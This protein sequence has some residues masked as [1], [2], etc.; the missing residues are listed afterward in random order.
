MFL[1]GGSAFLPANLGT[2][3]EAFGQCKKR[4]L[5]NFESASSAYS[6]GAGSF[7][8]REVD[9]QFS[10]RTPIAHQKVSLPFSYILLLQIP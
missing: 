9:Q 10:P 2:I 5:G 8:I 1:A 6:P 4:L 7:D 3:S